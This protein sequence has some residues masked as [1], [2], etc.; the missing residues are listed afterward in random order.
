[1]STRAEWAMAHLSVTVTRWGQDGRALQSVEV[2]ARPAHLAPWLYLAANVYAVTVESPHAGRG[3]IHLR[4][5][6]APPRLTP[7]WERWL[8]VELEVLDKHGT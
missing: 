2:P 6:W 7:L 3:L 8:D 4:E 1:M 5:G